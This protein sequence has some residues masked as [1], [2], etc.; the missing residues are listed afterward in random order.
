MIRTS[1]LIA[2][3]ATAAAGTVMSA[4]AGVAVAGTS[5]VKAPETALTGLNPAM[6]AAMRR[7]LKLTDAQIGGRLR[8]DAGAAVTEKRLRLKLGAKFAGAWLK[9]GDTHLTVAVTDPSA[10]VQVRAE[11]AEATVVKRN[12]QQLNTIKK[13]LDAHGATAG[14]GIH[15]W[16]V[17]VATNTVVVRAAPSATGEAAAFVKAS[18]AAGPAVRVETTSEAAPPDVRHPRRRRIP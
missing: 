4:L 2:V 17:D 1:R 5:P 15:S 18:G 13:N 6:A 9:N 10:V 11:G 7:D 16:R 14:K 8:T 12:E 3:I